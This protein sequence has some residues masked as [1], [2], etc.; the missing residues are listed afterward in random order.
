VKYQIELSRL[1]IADL[2]DIQNWISVVSADFD[3][4]RNYVDRIEL[5]IATLSDFPR[6]GTPR[7]DIGQ[8]IRSLPFERRVIIFYRVIGKIVRVER[9]VSASR[10]LERLL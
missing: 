1:A 3:I 7:E 4:A 8:G 9:V 2:K 5:R 10:E 6:R